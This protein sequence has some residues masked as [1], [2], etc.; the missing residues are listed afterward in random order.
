[1]LN[2][3]L[4]NPSG[5]GRVIRA[6]D[7][8]IERMVEEIDA[9]ASQREVD[10]IWSGT[11]L[12]DA[13][14]LWDNL[15][16]LERSRKGEYYLP[17]LVN[18]ARSQ[19]RFVFTA[20]VEDE[21]EVLGVNDRAQL[22][23]ANAVLW[24]RKIEELLGSGVTVLDP[25][26]TYI[27]PEVSVA[28]DS[29]IYPGCHLRGRTRIGHQCEI[30]PNSFIVDTDIGDRSRVWFSVLE[31]ARVGEATSIGP[32]SHLRPGAIIGDSVEL[33]NYAE[34]KASHIGDRTRM[35]HF[36][37]VG[38]AQV[39]QDVNI[40]AGSITANFDSETGAKSPTHIQD[41][42]SIGSDTVLVAPVAVG[43]GAMTGAGAVV[44]RNIPAGEVWIGAPA[45]HYRARHDGGP[46]D[47]A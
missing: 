4:A 20:L 6:P 38:D 12:L 7:G 27:D 8:T 45:R 37:Y 5:Y 29:T 24:R 14:W 30:G 26:T 16:N 44:T 35:H 17:E 10:E 11:M 40:G 19:T 42:A 23:A 28:P 9:T 13:S 46:T 2:A 39:G 25:A 18:L 15:P 32:F 36:S 41:G 33:G 31:G 3:R 22:A 1:L 21:E 43:E 34:V 47:K